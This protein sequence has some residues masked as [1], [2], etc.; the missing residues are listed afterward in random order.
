MVNYISVLH[1]HVVNTV[2][3]IRSCINVRVFRQHMR[4]RVPR[5]Q[6]RRRMSSAFRRVSQ[7]MRVES[8]EEQVQAAAMPRRHPSVLS[9]RASWTC[10]LAAVLSLSAR[11]Q[12][13]RIRASEYVSDL[14]ESRGSTAILYIHPG[15]MQSRHRLQVVVCVYCFT[16]NQREYTER[17]LFSIKLDWPFALSLLSNR[18]SKCMKHVY[19]QEK[20]ILIQTLAFHS[21]PILPTSRFILTE[22]V[23]K[24]FKTCIR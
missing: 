22:F 19:A 2:T 7:R 5:L 9:A 6:C 24:I 20:I 3:T 11:R 18:L 4:R 21:R 14:L 17:A 13:L 1:Y 15:A 23:R 16:H 8:T 10:P 12:E